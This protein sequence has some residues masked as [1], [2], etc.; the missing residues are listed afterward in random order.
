[1]TTIFLLDDERCFADNRTAI[2]ARTV[3]DAITKANKLQV[4]DELWLDYILTCG[5]TIPFLH[6]LQNRYTEGNPLQVRKL[7]FHSSAHVAKPL[8]E[9]VAAK[10]GIYLVELPSVPVTKTTI[11]A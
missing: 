9:I 11:G 2:V 10:A 8:I 1:M 4:I 3:E 5:D 6:Y 7:I